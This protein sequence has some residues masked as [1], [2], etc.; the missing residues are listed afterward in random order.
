MFR[1]LGTQ[2]LK[3]Y[4]L[5]VFLLFDEILI[6]GGS[7]FLL[8]LLGIFIPIDLLI[9]LVV[10][11]GVLS[12]GMYWWVA[13]LERPP[14]MGSE[15]L[16]GQDGKVYTPLTPHGLVKVGG[17]IWRASS[18]MGNINAGETVIITKVEGLTLEVKRK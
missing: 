14:A 11:V 6:L 9:V 15:S 5:V 8:S 12:Y 4:L 16:V 10:F 3:R 1:R 7:I 13:P 18:S 17:E 2:R